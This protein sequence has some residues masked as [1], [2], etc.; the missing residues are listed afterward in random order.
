METDFN[1]SFSRSHQ[2]CGKI[3]NLGKTPVADIHSRFLVLFILF[4]KNRPSTLVP[5]LVLGHPVEKS[6]CS[7]WLSSRTCHSNLVTLNL[8]T[9]MHSS[10]MRTVRCS[11]RL[12]GGCLPRGVSSGGVCPGC[13]PVGGFAQMHA[14]THPPLWTE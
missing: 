14:G 11:S 4:L 10:R 13:F 7:I 1:V 9:S 3:A 8:R 2:E 12:P 6:F 5:F